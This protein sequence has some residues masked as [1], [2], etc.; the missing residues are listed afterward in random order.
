MIKHDCV[1]DH[2]PLWKALIAADVPLFA[3]PTPFARLCMAL[4]RR[5]AS[6][7]GHGNYIPSAAA[8]PQGV[9]SGCRGNVV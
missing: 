2:S 3:S 7:T 4:P 6:W 5:A 9:L 1:E 8:Q